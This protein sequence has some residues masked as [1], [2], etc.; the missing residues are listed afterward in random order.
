MAATGWRTV[1]SFGSVYQAGGESPKPMTA[2]S[3]GAL[4]RSARGAP[5]AIRPEAAKI[6]FQ[7]G[8]VV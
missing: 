5:A 4:R 6:A 3:S 2:T 7:P 8:P 1:V